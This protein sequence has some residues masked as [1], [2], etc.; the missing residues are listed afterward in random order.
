[1]THTTSR[2]LISPPPCPVPAATT[3]SRRD[4]PSSVFT[5]PRGRPS[6][7]VLATSCESSAPGSDRP[8][9]DSGSA[10]YLLERLPEEMPDPLSKR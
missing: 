2:S 3:T 7:T 9:Q 4:T 5:T 8:R 6:A 10:L 1:M